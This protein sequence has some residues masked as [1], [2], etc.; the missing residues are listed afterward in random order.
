MAAECLAAIHL[1]RVRATRLDSS[2]NPV[3][4]PNNAYVTDKPLMLEVTPQIEEGEKRNLVGGCDCL[5]ARYRGYD[6]LV[7]FDLALDI[8]VLEIGLIE[9]L[10]G[11]TPILDSEGN[12]IGQWWSDQAFDCSTNVQPNIALEGWQTGWDVDA[13][14]A[15]YPHLHWLWPSTRWQ[16]A[17]HTLENDFLQP[18]LT[19]FTRGNPNWG[20]GIYDD[21][22]EAAPS[23]GGFFYTDDLPDAACGYISQPIT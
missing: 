1:C 10:L 12:P 2:G 17:Q 8:A 16:I 11:S 19:A 22:P 5:V 14:S 18:K 4:G 7:G 23:F 6:K 21:Q 3:A 13:Q 15:V 9:M 20:L